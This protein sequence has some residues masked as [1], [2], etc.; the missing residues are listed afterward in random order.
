MSQQVVKKALVRRGVETFS[1]LD[2]EKVSEASCAVF[3]LEEISP[4][5]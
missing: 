5:A 3:L 4:F 2:V 1:S